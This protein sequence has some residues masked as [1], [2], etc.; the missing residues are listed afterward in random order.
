MTLCD[1][2]VPWT[3][4]IS[5]K[6]IKFKS[7]ISAFTRQ[8][9][10]RSLLNTKSCFTLLLKFYYKFISWCVLLGVGVAFKNCSTNLVEYSSRWLEQSGKQLSLSRPTHA[11]GITVSINWVINKSNYA[12]SFS[13]SL[14]FLCTTELWL[15]CL[16]A[17]L[18]PL[19]YFFHPFHPA[20]VSQF[21]LSTHHDLFIHSLPPP[22][23]SPTTLIYP[24]PSCSYLHAGVVALTLTKIS[25]H[26]KRRPIKM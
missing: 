19:I 17:L 4:N 22:P 9:L 7:N 25:I 14:S 1:H 2:L 11:S 24:L 20:S 8:T 10:S 23:P 18:H 6:N 12:A 3:N 5:L 13:W 15:P 26:H 16:L 21:Q